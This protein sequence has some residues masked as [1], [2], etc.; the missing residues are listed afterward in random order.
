MTLQLSQHDF[1]A[2]I[3]QKVRQAHYEALK[4]VNTQL[5]KLYW[6]IGKSIEAK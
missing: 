5:I 2:D 6:E 1:I 4:V 3:K